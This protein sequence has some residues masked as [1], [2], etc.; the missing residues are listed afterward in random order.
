MGVLATVMPR[1]VDA[2]VAVGLAE[3]AGDALRDARLAI[4]HACPWRSTDGDSCNVCACILVAK[5]ALATQQC[6][7][8]YW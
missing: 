2:A 5:A 1:I 4:C 8:K 6:P 3:G 7:R